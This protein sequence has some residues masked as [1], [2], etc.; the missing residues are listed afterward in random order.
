MKTSRGRVKLVQVIP[1]GPRPAFELVGPAYQR[2]AGVF[3]GVVIR[4]LQDD[5]SPVFEFRPPKCWALDVDPQAVAEAGKRECAEGRGLVTLTEWV[6][7]LPRF[8]AVYACN[9]RF[10]W[11]I[12]ST[13]HARAQPRVSR[14]TP[15]QF[16]ALVAA[17]R[18]GV[19]P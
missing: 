9:G 11:C 4:D 10:C 8:S 7:G 13:N 15:E 1:A 3:W 2:E 16:A 18:E 14:P 19:R 5:D 6:A 12:R 17:R